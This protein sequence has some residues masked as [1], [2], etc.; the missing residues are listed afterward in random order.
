MKKI[1]FALVFGAALS[2]CTVAARP[3]AV[4]VDTPNKIIVNP[5]VIYLPQYDVYVVDDDRV[6]VYKY[7]G[8]WY[9]YRG[10][11]WYVA[12]SYEGP[13]VILRGEPP[14]RI[15]PGQ[16]RKMEVHERNAEKKFFKELEKERK[17]EE[18]EWKKDHKHWDD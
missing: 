7:K 13:W 18:K 3:G 2:S 6:E 17:K 8:K 12:P 14:I 16:L 15:P 9:W 11:V 10:G 5:R 4:V 1:A